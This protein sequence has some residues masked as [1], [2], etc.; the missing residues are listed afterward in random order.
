M[1]WRQLTDTRAMMI[2]SGFHELGHAIDNCVL[3]D[4]QDIREN[5]RSEYNKNYY[6]VSQNASGITL[7]TLNKF[8]SYGEFLA[9]SYQILSGTNV[10]EKYAKELGLR[11]INL[12]KNF[13]D[14]ILLLA[15]KYEE[16][17]VL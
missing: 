4:K 9:A 11:T 12:Q 10:S 8:D 15:Q 6:D 17:G 13:T 14:S 5:I 7:I 1:T 16:L 3:N 2:I